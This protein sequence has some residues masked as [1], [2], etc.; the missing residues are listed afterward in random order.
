MFLEH[1]EEAESET[2]PGVIFRRCRPDNTARRPAGTPRFHPGAPGLGGWR[3]SRQATARL[4]CQ[5]RPA[6]LQL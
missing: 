1:W 6:T 3:V 2:T 4:P 5:G